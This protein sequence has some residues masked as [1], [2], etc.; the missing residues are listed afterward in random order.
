MDINE[1]Y[2]RPTMQATGPSPAPLAAAASAFN[3]A[4]KRSDCV[5]A[6]DV[7]LYR[8]R[9]ASGTSE[10]PWETSSRSSPSKPK[11][12]RPKDIAKEG[13]SWS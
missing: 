9:L 12:K 3:L 1:G 8:M 4:S 7:L 6:R 13:L 2:D 10:R 11:V 5:R